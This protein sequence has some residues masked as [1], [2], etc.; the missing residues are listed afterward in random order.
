M[1][2]YVVWYFLRRQKNL[3]CCKCL[4][5][6]FYEPLNTFI[7]DNSVPSFTRSELDVGEIDTQEEDEAL[8]AR[9]EVANQ[10][11]ASPGH[12]DLDTDNE[13]TSYG[14]SIRKSAKISTSEASVSRKTCSISR[15]SSS[16]GYGSIPS[17]EPIK[18]SHQRISSDE[19]DY[20][21]KE[22]TN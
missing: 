13:I 22:Y 8:F 11:R 10:Y 3:L 5:R 17:T 15:S 7:G 19:H 4:K 1:T 9:A 21:L 18:S 20:S 6:K 16:K 14:D 2:V 12:S